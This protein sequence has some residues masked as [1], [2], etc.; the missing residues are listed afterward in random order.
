MLK[1]FHRRSSKV[2]PIRH[3]KLETSVDRMSS[4]GLNSLKYTVE[5]STEHPLYT[6][7]KVDVKVAL[8]EYNKLYDMENYNTGYSQD[9]DVSE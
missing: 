6:L 8:A 4:D 1:A 5:N 7:I 2:D 3:A 9:T